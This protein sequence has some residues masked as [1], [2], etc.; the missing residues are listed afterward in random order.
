MMRERMNLKNKDLYLDNEDY[1][2]DKKLSIQAIQ[3][4]FRKN[5]KILKNRTKIWREKS[6]KESNYNNIRLSNECK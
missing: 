5:Q 4:L 1:L 3:K 6:G 2:S